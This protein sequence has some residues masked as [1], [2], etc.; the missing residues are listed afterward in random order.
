[1]RRVQ[2]EQ[3]LTS[4]FAAQ[5]HEL[6]CSGFFDRLPRFVDRQAGGDDPAAIDP[7]VQHHLGQCPECHEVYLALLHAV[8]DEP[9]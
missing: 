8:R 5:E 9:A 4:V 1:M 7:E 6:L 2:F 3:F